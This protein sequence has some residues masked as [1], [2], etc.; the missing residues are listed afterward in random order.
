MDDKSAEEIIMKVI[1]INGSAHKNGNTVILIQ[2][3]CDELQ[4]ESSF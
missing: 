2:T 4:K 3:L 1:A